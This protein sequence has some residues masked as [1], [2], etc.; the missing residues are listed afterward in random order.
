MSNIENNNETN[1]N[2][3]NSP[4]IEIKENNDKNI[5]KMNTLLSNY[6]NEKTREET[7]RENKT[8][9]HVSF[10][11]PVYTLIDVESYKKYNEDISETRFYYN[12]PEKKKTKEKKEAHCECILF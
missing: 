12:V 10:V 1:N 11:K 4:S 9:K 5:I 8:K 6:E 7:I 3:N 2:V